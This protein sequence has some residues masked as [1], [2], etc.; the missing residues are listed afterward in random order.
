MVQTSISLFLGGMILKGLFFV[1]LG[2]QI[3]LQ[4]SA[5]QLALAS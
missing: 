4:A 3:K 1:D 5:S 2:L